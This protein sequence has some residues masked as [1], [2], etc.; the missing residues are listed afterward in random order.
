MPPE[1]DCKQ[2]SEECDEGGMWQEVTERLAMNALVMLEN[3]EECKNETYTSAKLSINDIV[4][5]VRS[6]EDVNGDDD[7][8]TAP[9][10]Q[11][12][13]SL[14]NADIME[15]VRKIRTYFGRCRN[16]TD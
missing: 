4:S 13:E 2:G 1:A 8:E 10:C 7:A 9:V 16:A 6:D 3:F 11:P 14:S 15:C 12:E 5:A